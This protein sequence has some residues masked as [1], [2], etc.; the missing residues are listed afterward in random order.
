M[1]MWWRQHL[2]LWRNQAIELALTAAKAIAGV[3]L[4][5]VGEDAAAEAVAEV[6]SEIRHSPH[7]VVCVTPEAAPKIAQRLQTMPDVAN[8]VRFEANPTAQPGDWRIEFSDG[9]ITF[10]REA[11][12]QTVEDTL[13]RRLNDPVEA[14]LDLFN[15]GAA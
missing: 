1:W 6:V 9:A 4:D 7:I 10:D 12:A 14:Q 5:K 8:K 11:V 15:A 2:P 3:A 13:K